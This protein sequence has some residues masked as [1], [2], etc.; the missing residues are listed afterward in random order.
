MKKIPIYEAGL[1][2]VSIWWAVVLFLNDSLFNQIPG[3][4]LMFSKI[5]AKESGWGIFFLVAA[6]VKMLG[7]VIE[8]RSIRLAGLYMSVFL[9]GV[10]SAGYILSD[11]PLQPGT[12][13]H[14]VLMI[15]A[16]W[17]VREVRE[18]GES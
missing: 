12:G 6:M 3:F 2:I 18:Y 10:I 16:L 7:I 11:E 13:I 1:S 8:N 14:F 15:F 9:Y 4:Y 17:A 5:T